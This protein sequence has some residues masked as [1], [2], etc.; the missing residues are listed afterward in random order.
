MSSRFEQVAA[1]NVLHD[2]ILI[3]SQL[4]TLLMHTLSHIGVVGILM[5]SQ[6]TGCP[7]LWQ[8]IYEY[9]HKCLLLILHTY[10]HS[11]M[12]VAVKFD[13]LAQASDFRIDRRQVV[14]L[15]WMQEV[16]A[17]Q[18]ARRL[19]AHSETDWAIEDPAK[20][21]TQQPLPIM[22]ENSAHLTSLPISFR[23][24]LWRYTCLLLLN[25]ML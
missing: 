21:W 15:C 25:L 1:A 17:P 9:I 13:A 6:L 18:I 8:L 22:S 5:V 23:T 19:N 24:W 11:Y 7:I 20:M 10:I 4:D 12:F 14:F 16:W 2:M 3:I